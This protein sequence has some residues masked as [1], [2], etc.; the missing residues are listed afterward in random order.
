MLV[1]LFFCMFGMTFVSIAFV[2]IMFVTMLTI[3]NPFFAFFHTLN[4]VKQ[5]DCYQVW[6]IGC[7]QN[8][9]NPLVTLS[10]YIQKKFTFC[11]S[12][13]I[14]CC[15]TKIVNIYAIIFKK[16]NVIG[17]THNFTSYIINRKNCCN[18][19]GVFARLGKIVNSISATYKHQ[20]Y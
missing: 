4:F 3:N 9:T 11:N 2:F 12:G 1:Q 19:F 18:N 5:F 20:N 14:W 8:I 7:L 16:H 6:T 13:H 10:T 17:I 15:R